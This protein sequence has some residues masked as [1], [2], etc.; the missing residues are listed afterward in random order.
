MIRRIILFCL[1][2]L[3]SAFPAQAEGTVV[4]ITAAEF[5]PYIGAE[6]PE[7]GW[8]WEVASLVLNEQGYRPELH[9][10]PWARAVELTR[11]GKMD[12][13]YMANRNPEREEWA[14]FTN[15]VG[16]EVSVLFKLRDRPIDYVHLS[17]LGPYSIGTHRGASIIGLLEDEGLTV[18]PLRGFSQ[19]IKEL[20]RQQLDLFVGDRMVTT[21]ILKTQF[22]PD[23]AT[24]IDFLPKAILKA[25]L[26]L[27]LSRKTRDHE[28]IRSE[29]N[30]GLKQIRDDGRYE[31]ILERHGFST[32]LTN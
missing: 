31:A 21:H 4:R 22:P 28:K 23:Y 27:A 17:D 32:T 10:M 24:M 15:P 30:R 19:G 5:A 3:C 11:I 25:D 20:E 14:V 2:F 12:G 9:I 16:Q 26:H 29:F 8:A 18:R 13:L 1:C 6:L 7:K